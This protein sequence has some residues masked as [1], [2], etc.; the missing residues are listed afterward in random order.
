M[1]LRDAMN[2]LEA[3]GSDTCR[4]TYIRHGVRE[5]FFGVRYGDLYK[6]VKQIGTDHALALELFATDNHDAMVLATMVADPAQMKATELDRWVKTVNN[7]PM[8]DA[9]ATLA[10]RSKHATRCMEKWMASKQEWT[11]ATGWQIL[12][13]GGCGRPG[14]AADDI[15]S[16][17]DSTFEAF[18][19][20]IEAKIHGSPNRVRH[21]MNGALIAIGLRNESLRKLALAAAK[22]IGPVE[23]DH[24]DTSCKTPDAEAYIRKAVEQRRKKTPPKK[25]AAGKRKTRP[26]SV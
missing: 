18:L 12:A 21:S 19:E 3:A 6:L 8:L 9:I 7:Q 24:G 17:P 14:D 5:P 13:G 22:R 20:R 11:A 2:A 4:K 15:A 10:G 1:N 23:V 25:K 16:L 26:V